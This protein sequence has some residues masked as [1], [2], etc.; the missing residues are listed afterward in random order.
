[1]SSPTSPKASFDGERRRSSGGLFNNI[2]AQKRSPDNVAYSTRRASIEDQGPP[3]GMFG[4]MW[5][6]AVRGAG[7]N[8]K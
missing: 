5:D 7:P 2:L 1:M 4:K 6:N 8:V 3:K